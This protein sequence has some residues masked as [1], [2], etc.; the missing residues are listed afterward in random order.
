[1]NFKPGMNLVLAAL[2]VL[3]LTPASLGQAVFWDTAGNIVLPG[4][5]LGSLNNASVLFKTDQFLRLELLGTDPAG[6]T[7]GVF[8]DLDGAFKIYT[9]LILDP[10]PGYKG[11]IIMSNG[12]WHGGINNAAEAGNLDLYVG[13]VS[14]SDGDLYMPFGSWLGRL[15]SPLDAGDLTMDQGDFQV[16]EG[17]AF[18]GK[19]P[20]ITPPSSSTISNLM[21]QGQVLIGDATFPAQGGRGPVFP[22]HGQ[23]VLRIDAYGHAPKFGVES[24]HVVYIRSYND[25]IDNFDT[26]DGIAIQLDHD[27]DQ[28][29]TGK[30][31]N[32]LT[33]YDGAGIPL[34]GIEG[35]F[36]N[37]PAAG[38]TYQSNGADF[39]EYLE[40][41]DP[42]DTFQRGEIVGVHGGKISRQIEGSD[43]ILVITRAPVVLGNAPQ[44]EFQDLYDKVAFLGQ[45]PTL[46]IGDVNVGDY[47]LPSGLDDG[48]GIAVSAA[49]I[50]P[51]DLPLIIGTAWAVLEDGLVNVA[52]GFKAINWGDIILDN[53][54][55][56]DDFELDEL[57]QRV[58]KL[59][60]LIQGL[61]PDNA[62]R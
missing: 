53:P 21:V 45:V 43:H 57:K 49:A 46:V 23:P 10:R 33:F 19:R 39:A 14:L 7:G 24:N 50:Q 59:E 8:P 36:N 56:R 41:M 31:H 54:G 6:P 38:V 48:T 25:P 58:L 26:P 2:P 51:Q 52:I 15:N 61:L 40:K 34:G 30:K 42:A 55:S 62:Q 17:N 28:E 22:P 60:L 11:N 3:I 35:G 4:Y 18:I 29:S 5:F 13:D 47:I 20:F 12:T 16:F 9:N 32:F 37:I 27:A 1:M 44:A